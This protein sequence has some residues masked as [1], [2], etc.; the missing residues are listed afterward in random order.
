MSMIRSIAT[1]VSSLVRK[2]LAPLP[3]TAAMES[4]SNNVH[5]SGYMMRIKIKKSSDALFWYTQHIGE[6]F[7]VMATDIDR[8]WVKELDDYHCLNFVL[9]VDCEVVVRD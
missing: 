3:M 1:T 8:F 2:V 4:S 6:T 7:V 5:Y 9:K